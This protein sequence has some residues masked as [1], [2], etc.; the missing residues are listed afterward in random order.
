[1]NEPFNLPAS[2][3]EKPT[4]WADAGTRQE[5]RRAGIPAIYRTTHERLACELAM[6]MAEPEEVFKEYGYT[7]EAALALTESPAFTALCKRIGTEIRENGLSFRMKAKA[8]SEELL[9]DA[10]EIATD[11]LQSGAV[12]AKIIE[13]VAKVAGNEPAPPKSEVAGG[14]G[15]NLSITFA[16]QGETKIIGGYEPAVLENQPGE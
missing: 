14:G 13:W 16:G 12:R 10:F 3:E 2:T 15:F 11:P 6:N 9:V 4:R 5:E 1:M 7:P 8:I